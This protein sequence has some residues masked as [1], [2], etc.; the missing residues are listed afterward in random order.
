MR[1]AAHRLWT[2]QGFALLFLMICGLVSSGC[3]YSLVGRATNIP[4][5]IRK[6]Y[7]SSFENRTARSQVE[8]LLTRAIID[9]L[10]TRQRFEVLTS[11]GSADAE[12][13][14]AVVG[15]G[16]TPVGFDA[17]GRADEYEISFVAEVIFQ[18]LSSDPDAEAEVIWS[19]DRHQFRE[20]Y[21]IPGG[22]EDYFDQ[23]DQAI[24][25]VAQRFAETMVSDLLEGF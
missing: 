7:V 11:P 23:E 13:R 9:E 16:A 2:T 10:V 1:K 25:E 14:G 6:V 5:D 21:E 4:E 19:N 15:Y 8:Q 20:P 22:A 3:G 17:D 12:I 18:R 24:E